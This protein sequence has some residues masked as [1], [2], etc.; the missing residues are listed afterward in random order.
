MLVDL[1]VMSRWLERPYL[2]VFPA[3]G[4]V[5][6]F[7]LAVTVRYERKQLPLYMGVGIFVA[8]FATLAISFWPY[9]I[10]FVVTID[11]AAAPLSSLAFMSRMGVFVFPLMLTCVLINYVV[12][13]AGCCRILPNKRTRA[14][15]ANRGFDGGHAA[16]LR[17][18]QRHVTSGR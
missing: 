14:M 3:I 12:F 11:D 18:S 1:Q 17:R 16:A 4:V 6:A 13:G 9:M 10:P 7:V 2:F 5:F 15:R 8:A